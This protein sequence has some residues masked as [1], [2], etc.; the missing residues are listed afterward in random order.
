MQVPIHKQTQGAN[1]VY[2]VPAVS[3][4]LPGGD[5][6]TIPNP[7]GTDSCVFKTLEEA[8]AAIERA[9]FDV[10]YDGVTTINMSQ[11]ARQKSQPGSL[12]PGRLAASLHDQLRQKLV[13]LLTDREPQVVIAA[14]QA[15]ANWQHPQAIEALCQQLGHN[16]VNVRREVAETLAKLA[17][18][19]L[20]GLKQAYHHATASQESNAPYI[21]AAV[22]ASFQALVMANPKD[23]TEFVPTIL[24]GLT[25]DHWVVRSQAAT[26][27]AHLPQP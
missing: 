24:A 25:D 1:T 13:G 4:S 18:E 12:R 23:P 10:L 17:P 9:G 11:L 3:I 6:K 22:L 16:D 15:L 19:S 27:A 2:V 21:R 14:V 8:K 26:T 20:P 7:A 5:K